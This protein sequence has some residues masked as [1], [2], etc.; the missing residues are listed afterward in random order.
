MGD[1]S[2]LRT[3]KGKLLHTVYSFVLVLN[4]GYSTVEPRSNSRGKRKT[5]RDSGEFEM[6]DSK[7]LKNIQGQGEW[8]WVRDS[9][10][11]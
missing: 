1:F 3:V 8:V 2:V 11:F 7:W 10:V 9:G 6:A 4:W 5:I